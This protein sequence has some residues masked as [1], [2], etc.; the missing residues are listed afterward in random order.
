MR[1][2]SPSSTSRPCTHRS[3]SVLPDTPALDEYDDEPAPSGEHLAVAEPPE[4]NES[5]LEPEW[6]AADED[7]FD[8]LEAGAGPSDGEPGDEAAAI[9]FEGLTHDEVLELQADGGRYLVDDLVECGVIGTFAGLPE[10]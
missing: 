9:P 1:S 8:A 6:G 7:W 4:N 2:A 3:C 10:T 5:E